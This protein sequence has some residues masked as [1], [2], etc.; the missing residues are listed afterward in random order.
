MKGESENIGKRRVQ[1]G[2]E[3]TEQQEEECEKVLD[4]MK[5]LWRSYMGSNDLA[6]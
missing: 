3:V 2:S 4:K 6:I 5:S 1:T